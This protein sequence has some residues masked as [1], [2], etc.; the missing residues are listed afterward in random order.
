MFETSLEA[1]RKFEHLVFF[2]VPTF[3][4]SP[5]KSVDPLLFVSRL[6]RN[7]LSLLLSACPT[8]F[9]FFYWREY[10]GD[11]HDFSYISPFSSFFE[12]FW[13]PQIFIPGFFIRLRKRRSFHIQS[14]GLLAVLAC[15]YIY[16]KLL[17]L[18]HPHEL[19]WSCCRQLKQ[20][21]VS[22]SVYRKLL[23]SWLYD[24]LCCWC[25]CCCCSL[26]YLF[27]HW[28]QKRQEWKKQSSL[29]GLGIYF[30]LVQK[31]RTA[32]YRKMTETALVCWGYEHVLVAVFFFS[33]SL[34]SNTNKGLARLTV[35]AAAVAASSVLNSLRSD[36]IQSL[37]IWAKRER[38]K[39]K[40]DPEKKGR[41]KN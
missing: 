41:K 4:R 11:F 15:I 27:D 38:E 36:Q 37:E 24:V 40:K 5:L 35:I 26:L 39:N 7:V 32:F 9:F 10:G 18:L 2:R 1:R 14:R 3:C 23:F 25:C 16:I 22:R 6:K 8:V 20:L 17:L 21:V 12:I 30:L 29:Q 13:S 28:I 34:L 19:I 31:R 33:F